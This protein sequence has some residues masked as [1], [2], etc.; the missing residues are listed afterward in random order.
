M[1]RRMAATD[2]DTYQA[3]VERT[4]RAAAE[5]AASRETP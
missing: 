3:E 1:F 2:P 5:R 4:E